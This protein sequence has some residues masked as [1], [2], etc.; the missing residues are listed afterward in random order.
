[1]NHQIRPR[2]CPLSLPISLGLCPNLVVC[3]LAVIQTGYFASNSQGT[4]PI[5]KV[6]KL[7]EC[8]ACIAVQYNYTAISIARRSKKCKQQKMIQPRC[9]PFTSPHTRLLH[10]PSLR[11]PALLMTGSPQVGTSTSVHRHGRRK[12]HRWGSCT[13]LR[14]SAA[15]SISTLLGPP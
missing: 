15:G 4:N 6:Q 14:V 11:D 7:S 8:K 13:S 5:R 9:T 3:I 2:L 1:L 10:A 12:H